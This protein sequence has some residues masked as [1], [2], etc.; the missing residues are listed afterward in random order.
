M[1]IN[2]IENENNNTNKSGTRVDRCLFA[3][4]IV[5]RRRVKGGVHHLKIQ[6]RTVF[7]CILRDFSK[8]SQKSRKIATR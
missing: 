5:N 2:Q 1:I 6:P 4:Q 3:A 8:F 7:K